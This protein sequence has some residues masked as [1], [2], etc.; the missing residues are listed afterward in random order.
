[1][2]DPETGKERRSRSGDIARTAH[3]ANQLDGIDV[4]SVSVL[5]DDAPP[6]ASSSRND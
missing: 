3:L 4:F 5:A 2:P 6:V 1:M